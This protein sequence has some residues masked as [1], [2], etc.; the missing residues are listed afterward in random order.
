MNLFDIPVLYINLEKRPY[1]NRHILNQ[2]LGFKFVERINAVDTTD[3]NGYFGCVLSHIKALE[4]AKEM[5][6]ERVIIMEDDF[7]WTNKDKF[8]YPEIDFDVCLL[9]SLTIP[10]FRKFYSWNYEKV[11]EAQHTGCYLIENKFYDKLIQNFKESHSKLV[12]ECFRDNYLDIYWF[13]LQKENTFIVPSIE[14]GRQMEGY[15]DIKNKCVK[16]Y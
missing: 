2:L 12:T 7:E 11:E 13:N 4:K 9:E 5:K 1:R 8:V 14:I 16:R 6:L 10:R 15:S 3:T